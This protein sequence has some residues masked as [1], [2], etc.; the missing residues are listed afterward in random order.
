MGDFAS[1][2]IWSVNNLKQIIKQKNDE[3]THLEDKLKQKEALI[4]KQ[5]ELKI[6]QAQQAHFQQM[7]SLEE[8][9]KAK[10]T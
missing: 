6:S 4:E 1:T 9:L 10:I 3:I 5:V 7:K 8:Q 2:N